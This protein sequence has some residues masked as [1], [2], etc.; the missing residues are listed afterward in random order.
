MGRIVSKGEWLYGTNSPMGRMVSRGDISWC[1]V[2]WHFTKES[3]LNQVLQ[4]LQ[5][6]SVNNFGNAAL[7][8]FR[9]FS[10]TTLTCM[11]RTRPR[12]PSVL[13]CPLSCADRHLSC[14]PLSCCPDRFLSCPDWRSRIRSSP[15][16]NWTW[17]TLS[18]QPDRLHQGV[19][20][21]TLNI[22]Y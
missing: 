12:P 19:E 5:G 18:Y 21:C 11:L 7:L 9:N 8:Q 1:E 13:S 22:K 3:N 14:C 16:R 4:V 2:S 6:N 15:A 17:M 20:S 10:W